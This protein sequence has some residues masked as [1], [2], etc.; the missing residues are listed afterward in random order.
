MSEN[1][2]FGFYFLF[3]VHKTT[4]SLMKNGQKSIRLNPINSETWIRMNP[5]PSFQSRSI[6]G[7]IDPNRILF[8]LIFGLIWIEKSVSDWFGF[9]R[10]DV[11]ELIGLSRIDF[12]PFFIKR[13]TKCFSDWY[14]M[15]RIGSDTV[16]GIDLIDSEWIFEKYV[17]KITP[18]FNKKIMFVVFSIFFRLTNFDEIYTKHAIQYGEHSPKILNYF[19]QNYKR[20]RDKS[21]AEGTENR[22]LPLSYT[23]LKSKFYFFKPILSK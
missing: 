20:Y 13:D 19:V 3:S 7:R 23:L 1:S 18:F 16:I 17:T 10:I 2:I 22:R 9:I 5:K 4:K 14:G 8:G 6:R 15:I 11:S 12:W 21:R